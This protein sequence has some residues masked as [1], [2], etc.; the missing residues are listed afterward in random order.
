MII[1][2]PF[3]WKERKNFKKFFQ[4]YKMAYNLTKLNLG[5]YDHVPEERLDEWL[6]IVVDSFNQ[7]D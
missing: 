5:F 6:K 2:I 7:S 4:E 3:F 1:L